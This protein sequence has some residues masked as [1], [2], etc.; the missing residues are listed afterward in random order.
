MTQNRSG[1]P[2]IVM[3][4]FIT[5]VLLVALYGTDI[6]A[7]RIHHSFSR[8]VDLGGEGTLPAWFSATQ[9]ALVGGLF[10]L[11]ALSERQQRNGAP[12][13]L[14]AAAAAFIFLSADEAAEFHE[15]IGGMTDMLLP[16]GTREG[17]ALADTG[18]WMFV[19]VPVALAAAWWW[20]RAARAYIVEC[21]PARWKLLAGF[22]LF[23]GSATGTEFLLNF[24]DTPG[25]VAL[26]LC[27]EEFG[28]MAGITVILWGLLDLLRSKRATVRFG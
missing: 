19:L 13:A 27:A 25:W 21:P 14:S 24:A 26:Q 8:L 6:L 12:L 9:L 7:G 4:L 11:L 16:G 23:I 2:L 15:R 28:E 3:A 18:I 20:W 22:A 1:I 17:T 10:A 5:E